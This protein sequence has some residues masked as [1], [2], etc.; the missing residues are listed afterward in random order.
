[1]RWNSTA[2]PFLSDQV[3]LEA[4]HLAYFHHEC[5]QLAG[6]LGVLFPMPERN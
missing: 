5:R 4:M 3:T 2:S 6:K 1:M